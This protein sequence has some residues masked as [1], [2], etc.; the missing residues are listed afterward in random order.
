MAN[1]IST[2]I[3]LLTRREKDNGMYPAKLRVTYNRVQRHNIDD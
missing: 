2:S 1:K 3:V